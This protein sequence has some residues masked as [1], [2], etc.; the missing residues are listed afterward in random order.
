MS[1]ITK[2]EPSPNSKFPYKLK[3]DCLAT[4]LDCIH[5]LGG[6]EDLEEEMGII[7]LETILNY[8]KNGF[9]DKTGKYHKQCYLTYVDNE[10]CICDLITDEC[11][12]L[13]EML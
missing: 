1:R 11:F 3:D 9:T 5:K 2:F 7:P 13:K 12:V 4:E 6:L 8:I 10:W